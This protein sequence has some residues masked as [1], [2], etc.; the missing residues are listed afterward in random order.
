M[1]GEEGLKRLESIKNTIDSYLKTY[2]T[3][4]IYLAK[5]RRRRLSIFSK[6][7]AKMP[8]MQVLWI[9]SI[10]NHTLP[11]TRSGMKME[12][13]S[14][15]NRSVA[16]VRKRRVGSSVTLLSPPGSSQPITQ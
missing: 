3:F 11:P 5:K 16:R 15:S 13:M 6:N 12:E 1:R 4:R 10:P 14:A 7:G 9:L 8:W 2:V